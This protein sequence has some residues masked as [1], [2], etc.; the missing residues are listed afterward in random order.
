[1]VISLSIPL[2]NLLQC[3]SKKTISVRSEVL[4]LPLYTEAEAPSS[5]MSTAEFGRGTTRYCIQTGRYNDH[6]AWY[7]VQEHY[8]CSLS[9]ST[10]LIWTYGGQMH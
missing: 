2:F 1:V 10:M 9:S 3:V 6:P 5:V 4:C 7:E 8:W